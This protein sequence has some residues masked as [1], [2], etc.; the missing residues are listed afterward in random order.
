MPDFS[1]DTLSLF[2]NL[3]VC[4]KIC[5]YSDEKAQALT[6]FLDYVEFPYTSEN[7]GGGS[8]APQMWR[9]FNSKLQL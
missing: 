5:V 4:D 2:D 9:F 8:H 1:K 3:K 6:E 7:A